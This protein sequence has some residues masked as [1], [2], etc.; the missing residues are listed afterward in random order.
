MNSSSDI[1]VTWVDVAR[2]LATIQQDANPVPSPIVRVRAAWSGIEIE[3]IREIDERS[4]AV[5]LDGIFPQR[6]LTDPLRFQ[7]EG[8][9]NTLPIHIEIIDVLPSERIS[10]GVIDGVVEF[11]PRDARIASQPR[12]VPVVACLS[13]KGGT[14][15]TTSAIAFAHRWAERAK[16]P[17]LIV[18]ADLEAPGISYLFESV[19]GTPKISLE[20]VIALA[21]SEEREGYEETLSFAHEKL[22]DHAVS[23]LLYILPLRRDI[24]ELASS[25]IRAE[26]LS[27]A[28]QPFALADILSRIADRLGCV[29][30]V[31]DVRAGLVPLGVNLALDPSVSPILV[32]T[33]S[34]QSL[35]GTASLVKFLAREIRRGGGIPRIPLL[36]INRVPNVFKQSGMDIKLIEPLVTNMLSSLIGSDLLDGSETKGISDTA[37]ELEPLHQLSMPELPDIQVM[38]GDWR[39]YVKQLDDSGFGKLAAPEFDRWI[40]T[41]LENGSSPLAGRVPYSPAVDVNESQEMLRTY[42]EQLI[43]AENIGGGVPKPLV[44][45]PLANLARRFQ[46]EVPIAVCEGAKGTGKTLAARYY[47]SQGVWSS[48]VKEFVGSAD[49]IPALIVPVTGSVQSSGHVQK[50][51]DEARSKVAMSLGY[52]EPSNYF[53]TVSFL[54]EKIA[55]GV[56]EFEWTS[57]WL[58]VIAWSAGYKKDQVG[59]G[60]DF[61]KDL[62]GSGK[63]VVA[64]L[65]GLEELYSTVADAGVEEAMRSALV[66][67]PQRLRSESKRPI[68]ALIFARRD[69]VDA[70][71]K[72]NLDQFRREFASFSL[73][74]DEG[75]VLELAAWLAAKSGAIPGAWDDLFSDLNDTEKKERLERLWGK[76]LGPDD[77]FEK[78]TKEAYTATWVIAVL[79]D[80]RGRLVPRDLV[81]L[82]ATAAG[83]KAQ[84][85]ERTTYA[86]RLLIPR[87]IRSAVEPTS[88]KKVLESKEEIPELS[89]IFAK[90]EAKA[91]EVSAPLSQVALDT[92]GIS[93]DDLRLLTKHGIVFGDSAPYEVPELFRRGL[94]LRHSGARRSVVNLYWRARQRLAS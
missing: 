92:L 94:R 9:L 90:F 62:R 15:R 1:P 10:F 64:I 11:G 37:D 28:T 57:I 60:D 41:E 26:H 70:A 35:R 87:S 13:V 20:D 49:A 65:E 24:D 7:L 23:D 85:D 68:G 78:R 89:P 2:R 71:I 48:V 61:V 42:A 4:V 53:Q 46:A 54:K 51:I 5:W 52:G 30:V 33:L 18:D 50:E 55:S 36:V 82:L 79:S 21:H 16:K 14:G 32:S 66:S 80:L 75:D 47:V 43:A 38:P 44:T 86:T 27:T 77:S 76:K 25:S 6:I 12:P 93:T 40:S 81:R 58:D 34:S 31:I 73:A 19:A 83:F 84:G 63:S 39:S 56:R 72:Q 88:E 69:T 8:P 45:K 17:V 74:W 3:A 22:R 91:E 29:G 67:L 59:A